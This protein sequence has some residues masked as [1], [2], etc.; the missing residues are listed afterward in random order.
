MRL[1]P[2]WVKTTL[3]E[4]KEYYRAIIDAMMAG[5]NETQRRILSMVKHH[6]LD[7][8]RDLTTDLY[9]S[10][11]IVLDDLQVERPARKLN[12]RNLEAGSWYEIPGIGKHVRGQNK[13]Q[14]LASRNL[15]RQKCWKK[16]VE[17]SDFTCGEL[18]VLLAAEG[19]KM[20]EVTATFL[21][22]IERVE[23]SHESRI[24]AVESKIEQLLAQTNAI[25][26]AL[27]GIV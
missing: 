5:P 19:T 22:E 14:R 15:A 18:D 10:F 1:F 7:G 11:M 6:H 4:D 3:K 23:T 25:N 24:R 2:S 26:R 21:E 27:N 20:D 8:N 9:E 13:T 16:L 12:S 17:A